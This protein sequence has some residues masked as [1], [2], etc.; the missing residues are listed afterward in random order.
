V[1]AAGCLSSLEG[2]QMHLEPIAIKNR[3]IRR[4][5]MAMR[6]LLSCLFVGCMN[7]TSIFLRT[8]AFRISTT[9]LP[10]WACNDFARTPVLRVSPAYTVYPPSMTRSVPVT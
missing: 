5:L 4:S 9:P 2:V 8:D 6:N 1:S 7:D 3:E 10:K